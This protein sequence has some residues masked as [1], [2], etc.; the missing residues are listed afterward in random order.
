MVKLCNHPDL[1]GGQRMVEQQKESTSSR[2]AGK[3]VLL[4][5]NED[6]VRRGYASI[7]EEDTGLIVEVCANG[8]ELCALLESR[9]QDFDAVVVD[10]KGMGEDFEQHIPTL[11]STFSDLP[12]VILS[13]D[14]MLAWQFLKNR[15]VRG[16]V[17]KIDGAEALCR[18]LE[19]VLLHG[20]EG[21]Y[22]PS[23]RTRNRL[24]PVEL[25]VLKLIAEGLTDEGIAEELG[26]KRSTVETYWRRG[27]AKLQAQNRA[28]AV[29]IA[30]R[31]GLIL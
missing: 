17:L 13:S 31:E 29:A 26:I 25:Q 21:C 27:Q 2:L 9:A 11:T 22:S 24:S 12:F 28:H 16:Y 1:E 18:V 23:V 15:N 14:D 8:E 6:F 19:D 10:R 4:A 30:V 7:L 20:K 3:R 5:D